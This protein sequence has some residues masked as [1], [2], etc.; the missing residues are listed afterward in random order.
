MR[1]FRDWP[2]I[3]V[4]AALVACTQETSAPIGRRVRAPD[5]SIPGASPAEVPRPGP[6]IA[7]PSVLYQRVSSMQ[8]GTTDAYL[9][10]LGIDSA[11]TIL[12]PGPGGVSYWAWSGRYQRA[13]GD[14][15]LVFHY[16]AWSLAGEL[17][18]RGTV[19]GDTLLLEYNDIM[20]MTDFE[21]G[22]YVKARFNP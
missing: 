1:G 19:R 7:G 8:F 17:A 11:F 22:V 21:S 5:G 18:A 10:S 2:T 14:S 20:A 3:L 15:V 9:L 13:E 6:T 12:Y 4:A 16:N